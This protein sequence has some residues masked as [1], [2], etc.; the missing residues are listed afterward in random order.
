MTSPQHASQDIST[1]DNDAH[2]EETHKAMV[3]AGVP[4]E[5]AQILDIWSFETEFKY[6]F[7]GQDRLP[8]E[9][10]QYIVYTK[11]NEGAKAAFQRATNRDIRVQSTTKDI[12]MNMDPARDRHELLRSSITGW[13]LL[14][15]NEHKGTI[16]T[17]PFKQDEVAKLLRVADPKLIQDLEKEI[18]DANPW[19]KAEMTADEIRTE[20]V[21]LQEQ[22]VEAEEREAAK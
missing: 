3:E 2:L 7:P 19:M 13:Y 9:K 17:V 6:Y 12:K 21:S 5:E 8:E 18:R 14:R 10:R 4:L 22:L 15:K 1:F 11:M 20:M 16:E